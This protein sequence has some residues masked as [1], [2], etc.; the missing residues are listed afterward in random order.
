[1]HQSFI[2]CTSNTYNKETE[3]QRPQDVCHKEE[4]RQRFLSRSLPEAEQFMSEHQNI[5]L[6]L[7][8]FKPTNQSNEKCHNSP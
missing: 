5:C 8:E 2:F 1:M 6:P 4:R 3:M 7:Q